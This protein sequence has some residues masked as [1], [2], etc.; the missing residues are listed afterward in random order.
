MSESKNWEQTA[1][2]SL[3]DFRVRFECGVRC[4]CDKRSKSECL[5]VNFGV[6]MGN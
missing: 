5:S 4:N 3:A 1:D 6:V 2:G